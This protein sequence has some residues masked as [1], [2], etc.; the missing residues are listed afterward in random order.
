MTAVV[1]RTLILVATSLAATC[2]A[3]APAAAAG[4]AKLTL[5]RVSG[6][7]YAGVQATVTVN[8]QKVAGLWS[9]AST[10][11][12]IA[13]GANVIT[14]DA[15]TYPGSWT[16]TL[17]VKPGARYTIEISPREGSTANAMLG[18]VGVAI[19]ASSKSKHGGAFQMRVVSRR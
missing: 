4:G 11:V 3:A 15:S 17:N 16:Q 6:L 9:G 10:T 8:G 7:Q 13:P 14:V 1:F 2:I 5:T 19:E 18:L 12:D